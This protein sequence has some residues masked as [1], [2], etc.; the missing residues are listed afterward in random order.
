MKYLILI[1]ILLNITSY[2]KERQMYMGMA[3]DEIFT[4]KKEGRI[5]A[6]ME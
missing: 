1:L 5:A 6:K 4:T 2:S 3:Y